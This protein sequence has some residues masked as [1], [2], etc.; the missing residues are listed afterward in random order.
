MTWQVWSQVF[1]YTM[2][3]AGH[4]VRSAHDGIEAIDVAAVFQPDIVLLDLGMPRLDGC[5]TA[6]EMRLRPWGKAATLI[7][8]TGWGQQQDRARTAD[9][10]FDAHL[11][12]PVG[13][14]ELFD[15]IACARRTRRVTDVAE[16][17]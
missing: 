8:L 16:S 4:D 12:K 11:V 13:E 1:L 5:D 7:A 2:Q 3:F 6:R 15:A 14:A 10:G 9:A 17:G